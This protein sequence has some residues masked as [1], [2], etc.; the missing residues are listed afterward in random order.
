[1]PSGRNPVLDGLGSSSLAAIEDCTKA[2]L[3]KGIGNRPIAEQ[4]C[5]MTDLLYSRF[6]NFYS[7]VG[8]H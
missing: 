7:G 1:V 2:Y 6:K 8:F 3:I 4:T 5:R